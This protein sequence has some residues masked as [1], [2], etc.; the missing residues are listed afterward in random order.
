MPREMEAEMSEEQHAWTGQSV[1]GR[2]LIGKYLGG[3]GH[4]KVFSTEIVHARAVQVAIKLIP[5]AKIEGASKQL[6]RWREFVGIS[7]TNLLKILDCG[8]CELDGEPHL[9]VVQEYADED[10]GDILPERALTME[11]ARGMIEPVIDTLAL[12]HGQNLVHT[13]LHP[14]NILAMGDKIKLASDSITPKGEASGISSSVEAFS[15]PEWGS[16]PAEPSTDIWSLG[17]TIVTVLSQKVPVFGEHHHGLILPEEV[18]EPFARIAKECLTKEPSQRPSIAK[19]RSLLNAPIVPV[20]KEVPREVVRE[21]EKVPPRIEPILAPVAKA[22]PAPPVAVPQKRTPVAPVSPVRPAAKAGTTQ[23]KSYLLP[24]AAIAILGVLLFG[25]PKLF[26]QKSDAASHT[27]ISPSAA[28]AE[29]PKPASTE[30]ASPPAAA[31]K[32]VEQKS[33]PNGPALTAASQPVAAVPVPVAKAASKPSSDAA[34]KGEVLD[35]VLPDIS[36]KARA[37]IQGRV[38]LEL[39]LQVNATGTVD[40]AELNGPGKSKY[41]SEQAIKAAKQWQFSAPEVDG[42]SVASQWLIHFEFTQTAT[43]VRP[44]QLAP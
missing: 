29:T 6:S 37:T 32:K 2:Y 35:Q 4:G 34:A 21:A 5:E 18:K 27:A 9:F 44:T 31:S 36:E 39:R 13:R 38:Q 28:N 30:K 19:V 25:L 43:N 10:L 15:A 24:I 33:T 26:R 41:F 40:S 20:V 22:A 3:T 16:V 1:A 8:K 42:H 23:K 11:E 14:G 7:H 17:A 12:L